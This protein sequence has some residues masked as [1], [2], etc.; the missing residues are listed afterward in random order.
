MLSY[1]RTEPP[2]ELAARCRALGAGGVLFVRCDVSLLEGCR[3]LVRKVS[4][5]SSTFPSLAPRDKG[6]WDPLGWCAG[7]D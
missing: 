4:C 3:E 6:R 7:R 1:F 5:R 2:P